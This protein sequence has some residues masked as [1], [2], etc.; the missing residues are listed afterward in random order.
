MQKEQFYSDLRPLP[1]LKESFQFVR[2]FAASNKKNPSGFVNIS[3]FQLCLE[4]ISDQ[5]DGF[6]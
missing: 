5:V 4:F 6:F 1:V 2:D 3:T